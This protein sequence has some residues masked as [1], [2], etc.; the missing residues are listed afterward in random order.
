MSGVQ[1]VAVYAMKVPAGDVMVPA[2]PDFAAMFRLSMAAID[3]TAE[4]EFGEGDDKKT[5]RATLKLI[6]V[7]AELL[8]DSDDS[9]Y[10]ALEGDDD[11]DAE[12]SGEGEEEANGGPSD[13]SRAKKPNNPDLAKS[14]AKAVAEQKSEDEEERDDSDEEAAAK[15][16]LMKIMKGKGKATGD[17]EDSEDDEDSLE[18]EE[19]VVCTLDPEKVGQSDESRKQNIWD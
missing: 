13:P 7:P 19:V 15:A 16:S 18:L 1:P 5:P 12:S 14:M 6:R 11:E 4:P 2:V 10:E 9:D 17:E 8:D 3:P